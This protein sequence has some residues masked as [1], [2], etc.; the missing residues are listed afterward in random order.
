M[1]YKTPINIEHFGVK[2]QK[3]GVQKNKNDS[4]EPSSVKERVRSLSDQELASAVRRLSLEKKALRL[5]KEEKESDKS[6]I[7]KGLVVITNILANSGKQVATQFVT[8]QLTNIL[9]QN[10]NK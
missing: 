7:K 4:Q 9:L 1:K 5:L 3:W 6:T 10:D 2:G 8:R